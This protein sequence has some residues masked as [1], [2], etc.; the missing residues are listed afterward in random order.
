M[1]QPGCGTCVTTK[2]SDEE[3]RKSNTKDWDIQFI[4]KQI[5]TQDLWYQNCNR[6]WA[7]QQLLLSILYT[8]EECKIVPRK[9]SYTKYGIEQTFW[10]FY[11]ILCL[12][13]LHYEEEK[14]FKRQD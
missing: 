2:S 11:S 3:I 12:S 4:D 1:T 13:E 5:F 9:Q 6:H 7:L 14:P 10:K 8:P